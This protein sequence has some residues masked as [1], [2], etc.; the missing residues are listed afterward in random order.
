MT[1]ATAWFPCY[2]GDILSSLRWKRMTLAQRGAYWQLIL[3]QMQSDD[4]HLEND[5]GALSAMADLDLSTGND[6]VLDAFPV[7]PSGRRA[8]RRALAEWRKRVNLS[9]TRSKAGAKRWHKESNCN[10]NAEQKDTQPQPQLQSH[11]KSE[12]QPEPKTEI[13]KPRKRVT[14]SFDIPA[15]L[16]SQAGFVEAFEA[17]KVYRKAKK[18]VVTDRVALTVLT[19]LSERPKEAIA[20]L[21]TCMVA[22]W[23]D[24]RWDW[25]DNRNAKQPAAT[26]NPRNPV[27]NQEPS[28]PM[29][30]PK[31]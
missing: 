28:K 14:P 3:W 8:N 13:E 17:W 25:I 27:A 24:V 26:R 4:G 10:A 6:I 23:T 5:I 30:W 15:C 2:A 29:Q 12:S 31:L 18:D 21:D 22:G 7:Q 9:E 20:A 16:S 11:L 19:R 1:A